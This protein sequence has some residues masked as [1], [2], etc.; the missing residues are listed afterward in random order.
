MA[1]FDL[2]ARLIA[3]MPY[4]RIL[5]Y[6]FWTALFS[7]FVASVVTIFIGCRPFGLHWQINPDPGEWYVT[8]ALIA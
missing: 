4:E 7:T 5:T 2:L 1:V 3:N 8:P 6:G